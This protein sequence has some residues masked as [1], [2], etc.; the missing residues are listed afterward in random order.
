M[1][2]TISIQDNKGAEEAERMNIPFKPKTFQEDFYFRLELLESMWHD[3]IYDELVL[4]ING[5]DYRTP[6]KK[7]LFDIFKELLA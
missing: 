1:K 6:Y 2:I 4:G 5:C 7:V 3:K